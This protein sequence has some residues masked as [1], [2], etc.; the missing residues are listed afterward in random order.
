LAGSDL[1]RLGEQASDVLVL[2]YVIRRRAIRFFLCF[3]SRVNAYRNHYTV[4]F[5]H[6]I[7]RNEPRDFTDER[8]EFFLYPASRLF[9]IRDVI[10]PANR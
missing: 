1:G 2:F 9:G 6:P 4:S 8:Y 3:S 5:V 10:I 7:V